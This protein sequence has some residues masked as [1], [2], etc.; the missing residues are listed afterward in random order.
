MT[1]TRLQNKTANP[2]EISGNGELRKFPLKCAGPSE[3]KPAQHDGYAGF[4]LSIFKTEP[5]F[6]SYWFFSI[7]FRRVSAST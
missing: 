5:S 3:K 6:S 2:A 1:G 4:P 7:F